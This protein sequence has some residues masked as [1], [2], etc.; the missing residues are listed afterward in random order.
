MAGYT[1]IIPTLNEEHWLPSLLDSLQNQVFPPSE[2]IVV[3]G[4]STDATCQL[5][6]NR[7]AIIYQQKKINQPLLRLI[8]TASGISHQRNLGASHA[9]EKILLFLDA[10]VVLN[11]KDTALLF[12]HFFR[13]KADIVVSMYRPPMIAHWSVKSLFAVL[14]AMVW[15]SQWGPI[16]AGSGQCVLIR[17]SLFEKLG[18]FDE[19]LRITED[20]EFIRSAGQQRHRVRV[21]PL[22]L[23]VSDRRF[24]K[25]NRWQM[26]WLY[27]KVSWWFILNQHHQ[28]T[29]AVEYVLGEHS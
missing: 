6:T 3:D 22:R 18:G 20:L 19:H 26:I 14:S 29:K 23:T 15:F 7:Q 8:Q 2:I 16:P 5:V 10:D 28:Q 17:K 27:I 12:T 13:T 11:T 4:G 24:T 9:K 21:A 25:N 1:V